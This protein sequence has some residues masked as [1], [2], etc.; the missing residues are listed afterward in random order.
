MAHSLAGCYLFEEQ[1][2]IIIIANDTR[3]QIHHN[4]P[5]CTSRSLGRCAY[6]R[7]I[8]GNFPPAAAAACLI[9][10]ENIAFREARQKY[11][12]CAALFAVK[13]KRILRVAIKMVAYW[14]H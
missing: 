9:R 14:G 2:H 3:S 10:R 11:V 4:N 1:K 6:S 13:R 12:L 7:G 5:A 8:I